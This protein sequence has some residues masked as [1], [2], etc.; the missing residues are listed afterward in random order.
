[1]ACFVEWWWDRL[2]DLKHIGKQIFLKKC[3]KCVE[4]SKIRQSKNLNLRVENGIAEF[5][6]SE[7]CGGWRGIKEQ[8]AVICWCKWE[9]GRGQNCSA[10]VARYLSWSSGSRWP[11]PPGLCCLEGRGINSTSLILSQ[12]AIVAC[13][14]WWNLM[15][16]E[17]L[18]LK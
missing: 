2:P 12:E 13:W 9:A 16:T 4:H 15:C 1:M 10:Q 3:V 5:R 11:L 7:S 18:W 8:R 6:G 17:G 14:C